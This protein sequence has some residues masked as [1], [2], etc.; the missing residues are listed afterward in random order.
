M[1]QPMDQAVSK[2]PAFHWEG[3]ISTLGQCIWSI[4]S[5]RGTGSLYFGYPLLSSYQCCVLILHSASTDTI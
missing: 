5:V 1:F 3:L 4:W 2:A